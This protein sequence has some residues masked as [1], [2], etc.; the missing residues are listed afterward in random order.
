MR[1]CS[2]TPVRW[3]KTVATKH[4]DVLKKSSGHCIMTC[5]LKISQTCVPAHHL[6]GI[7]PEI[8]DRRDFELG[9]VCFFHACVVHPY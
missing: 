5:L 6:G 8:E 4:P 2:N 7:H 9:R 1:F 3:R